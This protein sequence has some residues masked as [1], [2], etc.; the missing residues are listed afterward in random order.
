MRPGVEARSHP[1]ACACAP[2]ARA[3]AGAC[4]SVGR[5]RQRV[6]EAVRAHARMC[7]RALA[8]HASH[9]PH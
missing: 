3:R 2:S 5:L 1:C 9:A 4:V 7:A 8:L 6:P